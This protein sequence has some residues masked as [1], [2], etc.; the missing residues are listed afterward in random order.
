VTVAQRRVIDSDNACLFNAVGY[1]MD[2]SLREAP[3]LRKVIADAVAA[4]PFTYN[5]G[6]LGKENAEYCKWILDKA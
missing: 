6:F 1:V 2:R 5:D 4:D 3:A